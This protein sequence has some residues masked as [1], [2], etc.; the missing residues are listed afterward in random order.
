MAALKITINREGMI[1]MLKSED[2]ARALTTA[3]EGIAGR[4]RLPARHQGRVPVRVNAPHMARFSAASSVS[5]AHAAGL[6]IEAKYGSLRRAA[7]GGA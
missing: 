3:A 6:P 1:E 5:L 7:G 4:V 2:T